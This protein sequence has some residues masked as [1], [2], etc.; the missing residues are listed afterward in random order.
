MEQPIFYHIDLAKENHE[1]MHDFWPQMRHYFLIYFKVF[2]KSFYLW[3][4]QLQL[5]SLLG[6][7][8]FLFILIYLKYGLLFLY[9]IY[10]HTAS[11]QTCIRRPWHLP[12]N[13]R[14]R[15]YDWAYTWLQEPYTQAYLRYLMHFQISKLLLCQNQLV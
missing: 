14:Q 4:L 3:N 10:Q 7:H 1:A 8:F 11:G 12:Q 15:W 5:T 2:F 9:E 6:H 13:N